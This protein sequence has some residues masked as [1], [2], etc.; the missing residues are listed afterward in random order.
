LEQNFKIFSVKGRFK[1]AKFPFKNSRS[2]DFRP[3]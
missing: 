2:C 1:K 3:S